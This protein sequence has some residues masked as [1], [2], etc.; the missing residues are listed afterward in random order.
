M[1]PNPAAVRESMEE[2]VD[3]LTPQQACI[4]LL[5]DIFLFTPMEAAEMVRLTEKAVHRL[6]SI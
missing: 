1:V 6:Q 4:V 5:I 3:K 2:L